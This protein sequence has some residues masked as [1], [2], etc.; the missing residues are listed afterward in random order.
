MLSNINLQ[1]GAK[2]PTGS[3]SLRAFLADLVKFQNRRYSPDERRI[4]MCICMPC[5]LKQG[6][7]MRKFQNEDYIFILEVFK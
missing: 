7:F 1:G 6:F 4:F 5:F 2:F 3:Y